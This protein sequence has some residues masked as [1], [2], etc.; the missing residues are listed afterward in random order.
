MI[1]GFGGLSSVGFSEVTIGDEPPLQRETIALPTDL[2]SAT[3]T[4]AIDHPLT[5]LLTPAPRPERHDPHR[6]GA[7]R[8]PRAD[9]ALGA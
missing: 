9:A 4:A 2:L 5:I 8:G 3:G 6:R 1:P 7:A